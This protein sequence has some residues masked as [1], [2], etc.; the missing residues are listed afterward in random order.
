[1]CLKRASP[2][3]TT[4][5]G[6]PLNFIFT[7]PNNVPLL[8]LPTKTTLRAISTTTLLALI[9]LTTNKIN[10]TSLVKK[11]KWL[12]FGSTDT[13]TGLIIFIFH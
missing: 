4:T 12:I 3:Q 6:E 13:T 8:N 7:H 5:S 2:V 11:G 9:T 10:N 1:L